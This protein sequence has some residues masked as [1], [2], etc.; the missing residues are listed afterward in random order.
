ME[1]DRWEW[2]QGPV[3]LPDIAPGPRCQDAR[4]LSLDVV[5]GVGSEGAAV[6]GAEDLVVA[7]ADG[8]TCSLL[9]AFRAGCGSAT[10]RR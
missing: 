8:E 7:D 4:I 3:A 6:P 2:E 1:Q 9:P 10:S 5:L